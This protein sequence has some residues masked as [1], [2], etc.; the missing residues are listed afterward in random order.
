L[1]DGKEQELKVHAAKGADVRE[2]VFAI[3]AQNQI[4]VLEMHT[5]VKSLEDVFL[6]ITQEG[7]QG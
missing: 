5:I 7:E 6:E 4:P 3:L 2:T 1:R